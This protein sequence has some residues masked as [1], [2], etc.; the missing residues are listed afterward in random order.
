MDGVVDKSATVGSVATS[1]GMLKY[2]D[3]KLLDLL[4][5]W[6]ATHERVRR[7]QDVAALVVTAATLGHDLRD[8]SRFSQVR[9]FDRPPS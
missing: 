9:P 5:D 2:K 1:L 4:A 3:A 8:R 7:T 6:M